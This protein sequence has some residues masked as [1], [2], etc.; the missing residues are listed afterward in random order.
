VWDVADLADHLA[1]ALLAAEAGFAAAQAPHG[2][3]ELD[4][5]ALQALAAAALARDFEITREAHYPSATGKLS[6]RRRCDLVVTPRGRPLQTGAQLGLFDPRDP[7]PPEEALWLELKGAWQ[8]RP[9]YGGQWRR[10]V[11]ADLR[12]MAAD[13]R[14]RHAH[15]ALIAF[16][17]SE[18]ILSKDL[19]TF[20]SLLVREEVLA[21]F[22]RVRS[23]AI[24]DRIGHRLCSV[25]VWP[26]IGA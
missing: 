3:D 1:A 24:Q 7:C 22:R 8:R 19:D 17:E 10:A 14:I 18:A 21:G 16:N 9:T 26:T 2:L 6:H 12:K 20:E 11:V 5:L 4:E 13:P 15:L 25:A 23:I